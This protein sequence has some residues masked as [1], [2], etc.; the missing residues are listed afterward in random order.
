MGR[1]R[2]LAAAYV[3]NTLN[4]GIAS[5]HSIAYLTALFTAL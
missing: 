4:P 1:H 2:S 5:P 3:T